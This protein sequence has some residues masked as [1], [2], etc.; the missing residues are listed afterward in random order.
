MPAPVSTTSATHS[1]PIA[2]GGSAGA[3]P[4]MIALSTSQVVAATGLTIA[5]TRDSSCGSGRSRHST[6]FSPT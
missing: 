2:N 6:R 1:W 3:R 4:R 5:S